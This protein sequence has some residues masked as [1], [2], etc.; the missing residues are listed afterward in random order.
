MGKSTP[1]MPPVI[2]PPQMNFTNP[3]NDTPS[4]PQMPDIPKA[5]TSKAQLDTSTDPKTRELR[6]TQEA[7]K[8]SIADTVVTSPLDEGY[9]KKRLKTILG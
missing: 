7:S 9:D 8:F 3:Y 6:K 4:Q 5:P 2:I 1:S